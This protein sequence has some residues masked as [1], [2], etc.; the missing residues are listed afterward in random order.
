MDV[1]ALDAALEAVLFACG[2]MVALD[3]LSELLAAEKSEVETSASRLAE[4]LKNDFSGIELVQ[5]EDAY[6]LCTKNIFSAYVKKAVENNKTSP[7]SKAS[8]ETLAIISYNQPVTKAFVET[9]RG[10]DSDSVVNSLR[11]K[12]LIKECGQLDAPGRP[13]LFATTENFLRCFGLK[14]LDMLPNP[15]AKETQTL[16]LGEDE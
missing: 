5:I 14:S 8:L 3:R 11:E 4:R 2:E 9:V 1:L 10:V 7:L 16:L 13:S 12:G 6:Q 15:G